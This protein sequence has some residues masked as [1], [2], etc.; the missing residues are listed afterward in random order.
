MTNIIIFPSIKKPVPVPV[1]V[2]DD[3]GLGSKYLATRDLSIKDIAKLVR[4]DLKEKYSVKDGW[5]FSVRTSFFAG[6]CSISVDIKAAPFVD[7]VN[8][9]YLEWEKSIPTGCHD[10]DP[11]HYI[12][13]IYNCMDCI[14]NILEAF[15]Y[16]H[17]DSMVD[18]FDVRFYSN[19]RVNL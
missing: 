7:I 14:N 1:Q 17:S 2:V 11:K 4:A 19:V 6:G 18:Y 8:P 12:E 3:S 5:K 13:E 15:N 9:L 10:S 16:D